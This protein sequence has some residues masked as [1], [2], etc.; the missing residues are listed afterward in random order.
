MDLTILIITYNQEKYIREC[1]DSIL[2][3][4]LP[5]SFE[6]VIAD[7]CS[8]DNT[9]AIIF[10]V[11]DKLTIDYRVL[12]CSKNLGIDKNY[13]R[14]FE[15]CRGKY[16]AVMEGDDYWTDPRRI[17]KH[18]SFLDEHRE[19]VMSFN[20]LIIFMQELGTFTVHKWESDEDFQYF[21]SNRI[22]GGYFIGNLSACLFRNSALKKLKNDFYEIGIMADWGLGI[23]LGQIGLLGKL[24]EITSV[25]RVHSE[26][27]WNHRTITQKH[28]RL[29]S[30]IDE[31]NKYFNYHYDKEFIRFKRTLQVRKLK[32]PRFL[33]GVALRIIGL[34]VK[35]FGA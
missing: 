14:G 17:E 3:Q 19:C 11:L 34:K 31:Y 4:D 24:K 26:G 18:I 21:T 25:H 30:K 35:L 13:K 15:S 32:L 16:I 2:M 33:S 23:A 12:E 29:I 1:L 8:T 20:R 5:E 6:I 27:Y 28:D 10:E 9:L 22:A 7:D